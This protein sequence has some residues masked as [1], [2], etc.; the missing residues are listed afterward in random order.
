MPDRPT[1]PTA[2]PR[3]TRPLPAH[4]SRRLAA[5]LVTGT[6]AAAL[7][8]AGCTGS[9]SG[10]GGSG[11]QR[12]T[13]SEA[14]APR[15]S[16]SARTDRADPTLL[17]DGSRIFPDD[18]FW[19]QRVGDAPVA[20]DSDANAGIA[21][22]NVWKY[23]AAIVTVAADQPRVD[24]AFS[25]CQHKGYTP[26]GLTGDGGQFSQVPLPDDLS[27]NGGTDSSLALY[28][29]QTHELWEFWKLHREDGHWSACWGGHIPDT[30]TSPGYFEGGFGTTATGLAGVA[31]AVHLADVR[32]GR[33]DH[34]LTIAVRSA[35]PWKH[36][37]WPAQRSD[38]SST[39]ADVPVVEGQRFRLDP[40]VDVDAL[41]LT[42]IGR[43]VAHAAQD[44]GLVVSDKAGTVSVGGEGG[45]EEAAVTGR[46]PWHE[47]LDGEKSYQVLKG[48]PWDR[49]QALP[50]DYGKPD[51]VKSHAG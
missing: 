14:A 13:S 2:S 28:S 5:G 46:N 32:R 45:A 24:V 50:V 43:L 8:L 36:W 20:A 35:A 10:S 15:S 49:L 17:Y 26:R 3:R 41:H 18:T 34:A 11:G 44:Y 1:S 42:R 12:G 4:R 51:G 33:I 30:R 22:F 31:G 16:P 48:F 38:G 40:S 47:L 6:A 23:N 7:A 25:D 29:P 19:Y 39:T 37:S 9:S 21:S 27:T